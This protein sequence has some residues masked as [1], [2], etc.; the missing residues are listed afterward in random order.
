MRGSERSRRPWR[1]R[2]GDAFDRVW[3]DQL[4]G[5]AGRT[6]PHL[7]GWSLCLALGT[8]AAVGTAQLL[9]LE[10]GCQTVLLDG[11]TE[12]NMGQFVSSLCIK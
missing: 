6:E 5:C 9:V 10:E 4:S 7:L 3:L 12:G 1:E 8:E 2:R 11:I